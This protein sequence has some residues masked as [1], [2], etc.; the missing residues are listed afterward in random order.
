MAQP[1]RGGGALHSARAYLAL[2]KEILTG[3]LR[4]L[5][6]LS[7]AAI[8]ERMHIS[9]TPIREGLHRLA[10]EGLVTVSR[11]RWVVRAFAADD[12]REL[13]EVRTALETYIAGLACSEISAEITAKL[14]H[15]SEGSC[16]P[17][18][19]SLAEPVETACEFHQLLIVNCS[20]LRLRRLVETNRFQLSTCQVEVTSHP[21]ETGVLTKQHASVVS[22]IQRADVAAAERVMRDHLEFLGSTLSP[23]SLEPKTTQ[24]AQRR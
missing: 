6:T 22:A 11:R 4:P 13:Y 20:N 19:N 16:F 23:L 9:R 8:S 10:A 15:A 18:G 24:R 3:C 17:F 5:E 2:R 12:I 1:V 7:E 21:C 14:K